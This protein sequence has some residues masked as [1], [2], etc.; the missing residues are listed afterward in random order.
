M[1]FLPTHSKEHP[2]RPSTLRPGFVRSLVRSL[3]LTAAAVGALGAVACGS[4]KGKSVSLTGAGATF[5]YPV[6]SKWFDAYY[7]ASGNQ[8]NYQSLGSG[9]GV[10]QFTEGTV[11]FGATDGPMTDEEIAAINGAV[12]HIPTVLGA[13]AVTWNLPSLGATQLRFD[14]AAL[15]DI[16]LGKITKWN[17]ARLVA[18]NPGVALPNKDILVVHRSDG[19]G[20]TYIWTDYLSAVSEEWRTKVGRGK[21][22]NWP[23]GLGGKGNEGVTQQV[24]QVEGTIGY[25]ELIYA[26]ANDL[27]YAAIKNR[28][29]NFVSPTLESVS[30]AAAGVALPPDTDFRVSIVDAAG[31]DAYPVASFTWL[32][33]HPDVADVDKARAIKEFLT[34]M[35]TPEAA[36]MAA[37]LHYSPLPPSVT[38]LVKARLATLSA[39]GAV[40]D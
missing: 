36:A 37:E 31:A 12:I 19:S 9:A 8:V 18:L 3:V 32:L 30:A 25:V 5:P 1:Q 21:S 2:M 38:E 33:I 35:T 15:A 13:D 4:G 29:G 17:D 7:Q 23:V 27:P 34:W 11:D 40:I 24:K 26:I 39:A 28:S 10:K 22:V 14:A 20:T 6:Y 16:F